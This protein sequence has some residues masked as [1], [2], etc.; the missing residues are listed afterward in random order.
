MASQNYAE[1]NEESL[2]L[3]RRENFA[4]AGELFDVVG[5]N[6]VDKVKNLLCYTDKSEEK[7]K[8]R[9]WYV[10]EKSWNDWIAL[11]AAAEA[12]YTTMAQLLI[13]CGSEINA[14]SEVQYTPLHLG[15]G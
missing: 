4:K 11:H 2:D 9:M 12:G 5:Q 15:L 1:N 3:I 7:I 14:L 13:D 6:N 10:N 8:F